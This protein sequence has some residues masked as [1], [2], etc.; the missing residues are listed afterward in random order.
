MK[1][2]PEKTRN[3]KLDDLYQRH[4]ALLEKIYLGHLDSAEELGKTSIRAGT[5]SLKYSIL[6]PIRFFT[7]FW[8]PQNNTEIL[9]KSAEEISA[10]KS[11]QHLEAA[12]N[13][14]EYM[15][16][17]EIAFPKKGESSQDKAAYA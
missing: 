2:P 6:S 7:Q 1:N 14:K 16:S 15:S 12:M 10:R 13:A 5:H 17:K 3:K 11:V 8:G 4:T 9:K